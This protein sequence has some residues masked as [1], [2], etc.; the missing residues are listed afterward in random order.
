MIWKVRKDLGNWYG[1]FKMGG[2]SITNRY[3]LAA[4]L[5]P[6]KDKHHSEWTPAFVGLVICVRCGV[7]RI[8]STDFFGCI[9]WE[10]QFFSTCLFRKQIFLGIRNQ[11]AYLWSSRRTHVQRL[12]FEFWMDMCIFTPKIQNTKFLVNLYKPTFGLLDTT[13]VEIPTTYPWN[14]T[15]Y[16]RKIPKSSRKKTH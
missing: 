15:S 10:V 3:V 6:L 11:Q 16:I 13:W 4:T 5:Q 12:F 2:F 14:F 9:N 8:L 1:N 7:E